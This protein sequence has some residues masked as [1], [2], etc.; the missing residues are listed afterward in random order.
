MI[1]IEVGTGLMPHRQV[2]GPPGRGRHGD[3]DQVRAERIQSRGLGVE[4]DRALRLQKLARKSRELLLGADHL[5]FAERRPRGDGGRSR[6]REKLARRGRGGEELPRD[7]LRDLGGEAALERAEVEV[8]EEAM[9]F[10]DPDRLA[11][12]LP[13]VPVQRKVGTDG[14][15][16]PAQEGALPVLLKLLAQRYALHLIQGLIERVDRVKPLNQLRGRLL[17]DAGNAGHVVRSVAHEGQKVD[18]LLRGHAVALAHRRRA[19]RH[20]L[21]PTLR[22]EHLH[23]L[24]DQLEEVLVARHDHRDGAVPLRLAGKAPDQV[25]GLDAGLLHDR[26]PE[27]PDRLARARYLRLELIGDP[28]A[29]RLV[30]R[31][32]LV[33]E[34]RRG[35]VEH[36]GDPVRML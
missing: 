14:D 25:I 4:R 15:K 19:D 26:N 5:V 11:L 17:A 29:V 30:F 28:R 8:V 35:G 2:V 33:A 1:R 7:G 6:P 16:L 31:V 3:S 13:P 18:H 9:E 36:D 24:G 20:Q 10:P 32:H 21:A 22:R 23:P 12:Q 34:R 27:K